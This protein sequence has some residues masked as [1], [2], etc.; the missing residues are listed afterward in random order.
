MKIQA[1]SESERIRVHETALEILQSTGL[2]VDSP[3]LRARLEREGLRALDGDRVS[4][5]RAAVEA[6]LARAPKAVHLGGRRGAGRGV[7]L[8]G[9]RVFAATDGCGSKAIDFETG[10]R[11]PSALRDIAASARLTDALEQYHVYWTMV[12]AQ[13]VPRSERV[14]RGYLAALQNTTKHVQII[15]VGQ[16][17]EAETLARMARVITDTG[18]VEEAAVSMLISVVTPLRLDPAGTEAALVFARAGLPVVACSMPIAAVTA[19]ATAA[20]MVMLGHA[21]AMGFITVLQA[22]APGAP[23]IYC[24]FPAFAHARTGEAHYPDPR[25]GWASAAAAELGRSLGIPCFT[26]GEVPGLA[27]GP[28]LFTGGGLL[29]TSTLLAYEQLVIDNEAL[30]GL[31]IA[32]SGQDT[33][34]EALAVDVVRQ[35]GPGGHFLAQKHTVRHMKEFLV[36]K[37]VEVE[38]A[39]IPP[40]GGEKPGAAAERARRE[41]RRILA[42]HRVEPLPQAL[43][44]SLERLIQERAP[45]VAS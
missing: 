17:W 36:P 16:P 19:P 26:T 12:S 28:D 8:D 35:V 39:A 33:G 23:V 37:F 41:A 6:A 4:L 15:D 34:D 2:R 29:E 7:R 18:T 31:Q 43:V 45:A 14:A 10:E 44:E 9:T 27:V 32:A 42:S 22:L 21:E 38:P 25:R 1:L 13:D 11:R 3:S 5:P 20:G 24:L 30:R 40:S